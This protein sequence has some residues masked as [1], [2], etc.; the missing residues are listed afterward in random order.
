M[1]IKM[2][3]YNMKDFQREVDELFDKF[4]FSWSNYVHYIRLVEE[5]GELGEALTVFEGDRQAGSGEAAMAF[6]NDLTEEI[7]DVLFALVRVANKSNIDLDV[8]IDSARKR[9]NKKLK[10]YIDVN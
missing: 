6:H 3:N 9:Y 2:K 5:V 10:K 7:G 1:K 8:A 4:P